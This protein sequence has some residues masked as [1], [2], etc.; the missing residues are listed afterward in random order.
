M[1]LQL[2][3][4]SQIINKLQLEVKQYEVKQL[5]VKQ[6]EV[7]QESI[8]SNL[9]QTWVVIEPEKSKSDPEIIP[10]NI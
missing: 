5:E 7:K 6:Y 9:S 8:T 3:E 4:K 10:I 2:M 1:Q